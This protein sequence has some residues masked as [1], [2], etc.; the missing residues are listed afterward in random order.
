MNV[1]AKVL[2]VVVLALSAGLAL[3]QMMLHAKRVNWREKYDEAAAKLQQKTQEAQEL[4]QKLKVAVNERDQLKARKDAEITRLQEDLAT[5]DAEIAKLGRDKE[6]LQDTWNKERI[7]VAN[8]EQRLDVK[9]GQIEELRQKALELGEELKN[10]MARVEQLE[11]LGRQKDQRIQALD[12]QVAQLESEKREIAQE[13]S[14]LEVLVEGL[15]S[16]G[17]PVY[18]TDVPAIDAKVV[19][20]DNELG[21]VVLNKGEKD[22]VKAGYP[23]TV[24]RGNEFIAKVYVM[25]V[26]DTHSLARVDLDI[27]RKPMKIGDDATTRIH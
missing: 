25:E 5:K 27:E 11:D 12:A 3:S 22:Q 14:R 8:L 7:R 18:V 10:Y 26:H 17:W 23:F 21:A 15:V 24:Y 2:V 9:D 6:T 1:F 13:K 20:V 4:A 16:R 19:R